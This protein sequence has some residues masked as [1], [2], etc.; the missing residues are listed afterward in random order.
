MERFLFGT[1]RIGRVAIAK[2][3]VL[4]VYFEAHGF[5]NYFPAGNYVAVDIT[6]SDGNNLDIHHTSIIFY[7]QNPTIEIDF[8]NGGP[9]QHFSISIKK[10]LN[11]P[12]VQSASYQNIQVLWN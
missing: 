7:V 5:D 8:N 2:K 3:T 6:F 4:V 1:K 12:F 10:H 9:L 11:F